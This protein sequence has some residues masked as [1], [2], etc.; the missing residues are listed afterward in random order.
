MLTECA[1]LDYIPFNSRLCAVRL[2]GSTRVSNSHL[3]CPRVFK[4]CLC[5][6]TV[7]DP[8]ELFELLLNVSSMDV[9]VTVGDS[10]VKLNYLVETEWHNGLTCFFPKISC[11]ID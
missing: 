4:L 10:N 5:A 3:T 8:P 1:L 2:G 9:V 6:L 11:Q 7:C